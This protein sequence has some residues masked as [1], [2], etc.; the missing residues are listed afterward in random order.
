MTRSTRCYPVVMASTSEK[1]PPRKGPVSVR[2][3]EDIEP[4]LI[5]AVKEQERSKG[6]I[7][8]RALKAYLK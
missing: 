6:W 4:L 8:N 2:I 3:E 1:K 5:R 7:I